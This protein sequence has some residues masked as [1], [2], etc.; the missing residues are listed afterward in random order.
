MFRRKREPRLIEVSY[1][2]NNK[3]F[4][5]SWALMRDEMKRIFEL[6]NM[7]S[8][9]IRSGIIIENTDSSRTNL[10]AYLIM[11]DWN[12]PISITLLLPDNYEPG[13]VSNV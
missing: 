9:E 13:F 5:D 12:N 3:S 1:M 4:R 6:T 8:F 11:R 10:Y 7:N 2:L